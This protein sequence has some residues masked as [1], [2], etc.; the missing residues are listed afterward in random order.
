[1]R[2]GGGGIV[3][4][5]QKREQC[6][7]RLL[8][9][10]HSFIGKDEFTQ[11]FMEIGGLRLDRVAVEA[12]RSRIGIAIEGRFAQAGTRPEAGAGHFM[13]IGFFHYPRRDVGRSARMLR[14]GSSG[15]TRHRQVERSPEK[16]YRTCLA[17]ESRPELLQDAVGLHQRPP[18]AIDGIG[19]VACML[20]IFL[21]GYRHFHFDR[22]GED[23]DVDIQFVQRPHDFA[24]EL[25]HDHG[26]QRKCP[27]FP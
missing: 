24:V 25:G 6:P 9:G 13:R 12:G 19:I 22:P 16:V 10:A 27:L 3:G 21:E 4:G 17:Y 14:R 5:L 8:R 7:I 15:K 26:T 20:S 18:E 23:P 11:F 1:M 2:Q